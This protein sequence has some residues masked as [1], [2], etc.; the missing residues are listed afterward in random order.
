MAKKNVKKIDPKVIA[1]KSISEKIIHALKDLG[2]EVSDGVEY[3]FTA[4]TVVVHTD[5]TDVQI[6]LITP[7]AGMDRYERLEV[8]GE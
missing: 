6:K 3:G 4:Y 8:E 7:K 5:K 2:L 1:K